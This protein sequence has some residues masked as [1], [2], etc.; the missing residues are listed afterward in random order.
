MV[1]C[2]LRALAD[3]ALDPEG[4]MVDHANNRR[5]RSERALR[6]RSERTRESSAKAAA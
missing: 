5:L 3:P 6:R 1:E 2:P 4:R